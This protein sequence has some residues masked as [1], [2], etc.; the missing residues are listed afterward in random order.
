MTFLSID[1]SQTSISTRESDIQT[2]DKLFGHREEVEAVKMKRSDA[3]EKDSRSTVGH[4]RLQ[5]CAGIW[6]HSWGSQPI[7]SRTGEQ[8]CGIGGGLCCFRLKSSKALAT[9]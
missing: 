7:V 2:V 6:R 9:A 8:Y 3:R 1:G 5:R 4:E